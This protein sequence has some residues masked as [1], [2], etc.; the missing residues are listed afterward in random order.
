MCIRD[1][2]ITAL[3]QRIGELTSGY[4]GQIA[5]LRAEFTQQSDQIVEMKKVI[6]EY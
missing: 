4:E 1:R 5:M 2:I 3:Q 6:D